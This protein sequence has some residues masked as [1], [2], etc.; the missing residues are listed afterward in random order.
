MVQRSVLANNI[1]ALLGEHSSKRVSGVVAEYLLKNGRTKQL[2]SILRDIALARSE[3][4]HIVEVTAVSSTP[5]TP[6][7]EA[8]VRQNIRQIYPRARQIIINNRIDESL[9]G[10]IKLELPDKQL[11]MSVES[12]ITKLRKSIKERNNK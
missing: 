9:I 7:H 11:D 8:E 4:Q 6:G 3:R 12:R 5:I 2:Q 10:G 1:L